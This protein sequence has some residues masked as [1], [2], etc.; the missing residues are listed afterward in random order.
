MQSRYF[1]NFRSI[2]EKPVLPS[3]NHTSLGILLL[4]VAR[5]DFTVIKES[6]QIFLPA[7]RIS[8]STLQLSTRLEKRID[9]FVVF[10]PY[11]FFSFSSCFSY[12]TGQSCSSS[13]TCASSFDSKYS[14]YI[15][16][17][18]IISLIGRND[19]A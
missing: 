5:F 19:W 8:D 17:S 4:V 7:D 15:V 18:I 3:D 11:S 13:D 6:V 16:A 9:P 10:I 1:R 2:A 12:D 14:Q